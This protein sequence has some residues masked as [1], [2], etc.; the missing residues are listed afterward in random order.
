[1]YCPTCGCENPDE[2][3]KCN[4]CGTILKTNV[5]P[6]QAN[7]DNISNKNIKTP[8]KSFDKNKIIIISLIIAIVTVIIVAVVFVVS[9][10]KSTQNSTDNQPFIYETE[11]ELYYYKNVKDGVESICLSDNYGDEYR[12]S[13]NYQYIFFTE[14]NDTLY[15]LE[16]NNDNA[17]K[18]AIA[19]NVKHIDYILGNAEK[20][21]YETEN[22]LYCSDLEGYSEKLLDFEK[23]IDM[24]FS[25]VSKEKPKNL[26]IEERIDVDENHGFS[27]LYSIYTET[28]KVTTISENC[29]KDYY[30]GKYGYPGKKYDFDITNY[31]NISNIYFIEENKLYISDMLG[32]KRIISS[33]VRDV[34]VDGTDVYY[35]VIDKTYEDVYS[36]NYMYGYGFDSEC[37]FTTG[38]F[39]Y[40]DE[41]SGNNIKLLDNITADAIDYDL[42][43]YSDNSVHKDLYLRNCYNYDIYDFNFDYEYPYDNFDDY[44]YREGTNKIEYN[45]EYY[46][47]NNGNVIKIDTDCYVRSIEYCVDKGGYIIMCIPEDSPRYWDYYDTYT[48]YFLP[49]DANSF[50]SAEIV[51]SGVYGYVY[52]D[53]VKGK[54]IIFKDFK[55]VT[56]N[57]DGYV[58]DEYEIAT[59]VI[60]EDEIQN[61]Y[62]ILICDG[63]DILYSVRENQ[64][65]NIYKYSEGKKI[66]VAE[67]SLPC[68]YGRFSKR[69]YVVTKYY[70][71][72]DACDIV[73]VDGENQYEV[74]SN[75]IWQGYEVLNSDSMYVIYQ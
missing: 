66:K 11:T 28:N 70:E 49:E 40:Y 65:W 58:Y 39:Y 64:I 36:T 33:D 67:S 50:E 63:E 5:N 31:D 10:L 38:S 23:T 44:D 13:Q 14:S 20:V 55:E 35:Q 62:P 19:N 37:Y 68:D 34:V 24:P 59:M 54:E 9:N 60:G 47:L 26:I 22:T 73:C 74:A 17:E 72:S 48:F 32:N 7:I 27:K 2:S 25:W 12:L 52:T 71:E 42:M 57:R 45:E 51:A 56:I 29:D 30:H 43:Y 69:Y 16:L 61:V 41:T 4:V 6:N 75:I 53:F 46:V 15:A 21:Y 3:T 8:K 1:M 18:V